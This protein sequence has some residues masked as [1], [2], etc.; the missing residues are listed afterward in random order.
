MLD[1]SI[2]KAKPEITV[3]NIDRDESVKMKDLLSN[4]INLNITINDCTAVKVSKE[5]IAR[6]DLISLA[7]YNNDRYADIICKINGISN[8]FELNEGMILIIPDLTSINKMIKNG[9][10]SETIS[11][12]TSIYK[13]NKSN[14]K[15]KNSV[16]NPAEQTF[17]DSNFTIDKKN[18][19]V[20]Y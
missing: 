2:I 16:R 17:G 19:I 8:P 3:E 4:V 10:V 6:P 20:I 15:S 18:K 12:N 14:Q 7:V 13:K 11:D 9:K 5:Y 1:Y